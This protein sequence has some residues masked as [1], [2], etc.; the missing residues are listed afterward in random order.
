M[1]ISKFEKAK[2]VLSSILVGDVCKDVPFEE[3][4]AKI[5]LDDMAKEMPEF[6]TDKASVLSLIRDISPSEDLMINMAYGL[7][8]GIPAS[9]DAHDA[10]NMFYDNYCGFI[11]R[12]V[13]E[14]AGDVVQ[15]D[16]DVLRVVLELYCDKR[17]YISPYYKGI[18]EL[19]QLCYAVPNE[20]LMDNGIFD[21][22]LYFASPMEIYN[23]LLTDAEKQ[24]KNIICR[25]LKELSDPAIRNYEEEFR[26]ICISVPRDILMDNDVRA[27]FFKSGIPS[28]IY[29]EVFTDEEKLDDDMI[30]DLLKTYKNPA[31]PGYKKDFLRLKKLWAEA[32]IE[33][34][35]N[36]EYAGRICE[37]NEPEA[38]EDFFLII[39]DFLNTIAD[40][41]CVD[42]DQEKQEFLRS[43]A[44]KDRELWE[45]YV[46]DVYPDGRE[47]PENYY[48]WESLFIIG[49]PYYDSF[50]RVLDPY[51]YQFMLFDKVA[52]G[53]FSF[54]VEEDNDGEV[55]QPADQ[56][57]NEPFMNLPDGCDDGIPF[58]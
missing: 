30:F 6:F 58:A 29:D 54:F 33:D 8:Y 48:A 4:A 3:S 2:Q 56:G 26:D 39:E 41:L 45:Q 46:R 23:G 50:T 36:N 44:K 57:E 32:I 1:G 7:A 40:S 34:F 14:Y 51:F 19:P 11:D 24:D 15:N 35:R 31:F 17:K 53:N 37:L 55:S 47:L 28:V 27:Q 5:Y 20:V 16:K 9:S 43:M 42:I 52:A 25:L 18:Y 21:M 10:V 49:C 38:A 12:I 13:L 22:V